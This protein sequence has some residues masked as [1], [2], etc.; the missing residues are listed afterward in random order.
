MSAEFTIEPAERSDSAVFTDYLFTSKLDLTVNRLLYKDWPNEDAQRAH[1]A[2]AVE[3][4]WNDGMS[5][6]KAVDKRGHILGF[7]A[8]ER[9]L[10]ATDGKAVS[11]TCPESMN[12][13]VFEAVTEAAQKIDKAADGEERYGEL[14]YQAPLQQVCLTTISRQRLYTFTSSQPAEVGKSA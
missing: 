9:K 12:V 8:L 10:A 13:A 11:A 3:R 4:G 6:Y 2:D 7:V 5:Y 1:Y 14:P